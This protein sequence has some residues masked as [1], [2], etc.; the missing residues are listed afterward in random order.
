MFSKTREA[1]VHN[2]ARPSA[3]KR[4][5]GIDGMLS[6]YRDIKKS[7]LCMMYFVNTLLAEVESLFAT[8]KRCNVVL[9]AEDTQQQQQL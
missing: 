5:Q 4:R 6:K 3:I 2:G 9:H 1:F 8:D 7:E